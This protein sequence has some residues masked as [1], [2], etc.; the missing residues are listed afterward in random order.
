MRLLLDEHISQR[1][2]EGLRT[3]GYDVCQATE[4]G[5][6][7]TPDPLLWRNAIREGRV[8][9]TYNAVEFRA[10][11]ADFLARGIHH[12][13]LV[14]VSPGAIRPDDF[15]GLIRALSALIDQGL[16]LGDVWIYLKAA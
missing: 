5:W 12:D 7:N 4:R 2:A 14:L 3:R 15:G 6:D 16:P 9:V 11:Y 8:M 10:I 13:G 1:V